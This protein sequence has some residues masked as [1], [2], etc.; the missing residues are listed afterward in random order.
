MKHHPHPPPLRV[1]YAAVSMQQRNGKA[2][3]MPAVKRLVT[4]RVFPGVFPIRSG[5]W[6]FKN[7]AMREDNPFYGNTMKNRL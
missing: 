6:H 3:M 2:G 5:S 4:S 7:F 1:Q